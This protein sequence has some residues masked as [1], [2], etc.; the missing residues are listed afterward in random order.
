MPYSGTEK[1]FSFLFL[2]LYLFIYL[3]IVDSYLSLVVL[4]VE[5]RVINTVLDDLQRFMFSLMDDCEVQVPG[6]IMWVAI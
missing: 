5:E 3:F 2:Y 6:K 4:Y 1:W